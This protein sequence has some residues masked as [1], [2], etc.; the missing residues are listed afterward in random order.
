VAREPDDAEAQVALRRQLAKI[1]AADEGLAAEIAELVEAARPSLTVNSLQVR[2]QGVAASQGGIAAHMVA[3]GGTVQ[4]NVIVINAAAAPADSRDLWRRLGETEP[5]PDLTRATDLYLKNL[6]ERY[7]YLDIKGLG[8]SDRVPLRLPLREMFVP[9]KA[10]VET[11]EGETWER[12]RLAGRQ[13]SEAEAEAMG[14][15][16]SEPRPILDLL[17]GNDGLIVLGDPGAGKTTFLKF[18]ALALATGQGEALGLEDHHSPGED[19]LSPAED[20][21]GPG[22]DCLSPPGREATSSPPCSTP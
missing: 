22:E 1:L 14:H 19:C 17:G 12:L 10:R 21:R 15:L 16:M 4:G 8:V 20:R 3:V 18:L 5:A 13:P 6:V 7:Q 11:P 2:D 9:L